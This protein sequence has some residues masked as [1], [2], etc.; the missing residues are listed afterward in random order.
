MVVVPV[1]R[2]KHLQGENEEADASPSGEALEG[3]Q[4]PSIRPK[5]R[6][7]AIIGEGLALLGGVDRVWQG[8]R[9][10]LIFIGLES[11]GHKRK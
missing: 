3:Y 6:A 1:K 7:S 2:S 11:P 9:R 4:R 5:P 8:L 10:S